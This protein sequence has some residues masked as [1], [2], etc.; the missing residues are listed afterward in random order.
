MPVSSQNPTRSNYELRLFQELIDP[1]RL[2][3]FIAELDRRLVQDH[4]TALPKK[5]QPL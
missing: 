3:P 5:A 2:G 4:G 1:V